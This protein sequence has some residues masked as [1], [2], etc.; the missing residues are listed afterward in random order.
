MARRNNHKGR[1]NGGES[2]STAQR[3][4]E[5]RLN[6]NYSYSKLAALIGGIDPSTLPHALLAHRDFSRRIARKIEMFLE[7]ARV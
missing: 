4:E 5:F 6:K 7:G 2:L 3:L 1:G